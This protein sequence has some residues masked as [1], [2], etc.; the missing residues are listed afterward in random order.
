MF[1]RCTDSFFG[2]C[3]TSV[4]CLC[5]LA[6]T[7]LCMSSSFQRIGSFTYMT[8]SYMNTFM[9]FSCMARHA[10][11]LTTCM[12]FSRG[13]RFPGWSQVSM[14]SSSMMTVAQCCRKRKHSSE[15]ECVYREM[16]TYIH[17]YIH[18]HIYTYVYTFI[19]IYI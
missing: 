3:V 14:L 15:R 18:T 17:A 8:C 11:H 12:T 19:Y 13:L 2:D 6:K 9:T 4:C 7:L 10:T 5:T 16:H 1:H